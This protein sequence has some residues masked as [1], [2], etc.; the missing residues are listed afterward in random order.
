M[1]LYRNKGNETHHLV[2][3]HSDD[4]A[5]LVKLIRCHVPFV[6]AQGINVQED[7]GEW[8]HGNYFETIEEAVA[9]YKNL[10]RPPWKD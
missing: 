4:I 6:V 5:L 7:S 9:K 2:L 1:K 3:A 10:T 8:N